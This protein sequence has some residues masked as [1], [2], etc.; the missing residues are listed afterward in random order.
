MGVPFKDVL[1]K[2][3]L[4]FLQV[5]KLCFSVLIPYIANRLSSEET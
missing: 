1:S 2:Q 5:D 3:Y 4:N